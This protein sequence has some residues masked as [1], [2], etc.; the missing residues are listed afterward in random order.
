MHYNNSIDH[1]FSGQGHWNEV[2]SSDWNDWKWQ[3][4]NQLNRKEHFSK[5]LVL[6]SEESLVSILHEINFMHP[7]RHIFLI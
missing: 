5:H 6:N 4:R 1:W 3:L 2:P 7:L